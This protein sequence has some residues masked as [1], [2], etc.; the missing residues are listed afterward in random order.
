MKTALVTLMLFKNNISFDVSEGESGIHRIL[1]D[2]VRLA[3]SKPETSLLIS[4]V[5]KQKIF[6]G[7]KFKSCTGRTVPTNILFAF[8][9]FNVIGIGSF[10]A[11]KSV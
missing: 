6:T 11:E 5:I 4:G 7:L 1:G 10:F 2:V 8:A 3:S 9:S